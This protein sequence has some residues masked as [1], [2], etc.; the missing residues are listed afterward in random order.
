M[1]NEDQKICS[2][3]DTKNNDENKYCSSC[4]N[5]F[6]IKIKTKKTTSINENNSTYIELRSSLNELLIK[7]GSCFLK[8]ENNKID[9]TKELK[10]NSISINLGLLKYHSTENRKKLE[11]NGYE[12][13]D[14][15]FNKVFSNT[16]QKLVD[17]LVRETEY[18]MKDIFAKTSIEDYDLTKDFSENITK[19]KKNIT[20]EVT[21]PDLGWK[22]K[23]FLIALVVIVLGYCSQPDKKTDNYTNENTENNEKG[24]INL[25]SISD[26]KFTFKSK[27][28]DIEKDGKTILSN[29]EITYH[30][31]DFI[32]KIVTQKSKL[33]GQW[34]TV[35]YPI[36]GV[37]EEKGAVATTY[38]IQVGTLGVSEIWFSPDVPNLGYDYDDGT[39]IA[40]YDITKE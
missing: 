11:D 38:I 18:L 33:N 29:N 34:T 8:I 20:K 35:T 28:Y 7:S 9:F 23:L 37:Y 36:N 10:P 25:N 14:Y 26:Q 30:T 3:C 27:S 6:F 21:E 12:I 15:K 13:E 24:E 39:R 22:S 32:N 19:P 5:K 4:G 31:F 17:D 16:K 40:C 2:V 1:E